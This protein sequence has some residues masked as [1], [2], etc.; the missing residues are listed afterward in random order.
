M[1]GN[2]CYHTI[3]LMRMLGYSLSSGPKRYKNRARGFHQHF[4][5]QE[6]HSSFQNKEIFMQLHVDEL[7]ELHRINHARVGFN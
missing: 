4:T 5:I 1:A 6:C 3:M 7:D 2:S